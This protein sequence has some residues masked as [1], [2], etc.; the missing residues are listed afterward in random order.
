MGDTSVLLI[1]SRT[2]CAGHTSR[3]WIGPHWQGSTSSFTASSRGLLV[4]RARTTEGSSSSSGS[5]SSVASE[6]EARVATQ[7]SPPVGCKA[8]G[9]TDLENGCNG[10][11]RIQGGIG[12]LPGFD[13]WPIKAYRP[14]PAFL[15]SG[16]RYRRS[17]QSLNELAFG[18]K[19][20]GDDLD[21]S[22][23]LKR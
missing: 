4:V 13:W 11:G 16:G 18:Q 8:C 7:S 21:V 22:E 17:G 14:C 1:G 10:E 20:S 19:T 12:A 5:S 9:R 15:Q 3:K 2:S 6:K 23:R